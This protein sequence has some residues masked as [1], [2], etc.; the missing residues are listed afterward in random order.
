VRIL[1]IEDSDSIRHMIETL[2]SSRGHKVVA[3]STGA[4]GI[5]AARADLPHHTSRADHHHQRDVRS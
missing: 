5:E 2:V 1:V 4:K 3:V